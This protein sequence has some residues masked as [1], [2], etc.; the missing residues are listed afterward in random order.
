[1]DLEYGLSSK[2]QG[3]GS[4]KGAEKLPVGIFEDES[5]GGGYD[6]MNKAAQSLSVGR[7]IMGEMITWSG[8]IVSF[9]SSL[10]IVGKVSSCNTTFWTAQSSSLMCP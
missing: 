3:V 2:P 1:M 9:L 7:S 6:P 10:A 5:W 8:Y 4:K